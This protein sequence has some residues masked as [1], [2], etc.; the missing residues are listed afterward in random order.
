M[1]TGCFESLSQGTC[2][3]LG[4]NEAFL[5][6]VRWSRKERRHSGEARA[7]VSSV[8][9]PAVVRRQ[10]CQGGEQR[11]L[12]QIWCGVVFGRLRSLGSRH[13][14]EAEGCCGPVS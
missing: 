5:M 9:C 6:E 1:G 14:L 3:Q 4:F 8:R 12:G 13:V 11:A 2:P 10:A 7:E